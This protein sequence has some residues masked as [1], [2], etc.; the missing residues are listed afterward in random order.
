MAWYFHQVTALIT[1]KD[2]LVCVWRTA[3]KA[4]DHPS[5]NMAQNDIFHNKT[6]I[7]LAV[8][9]ITI[10][11]GMQSTEVRNWWEI[12]CSS[13]QSEPS[14]TIESYCTMNA[15]AEIVAYSI[16]YLSIPA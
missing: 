2:R 11:P 1:V 16:L 7:P 14:D 9:T 5:S 3:T 12:L 4:L 13:L 10:A 6:S 8:E 15:I